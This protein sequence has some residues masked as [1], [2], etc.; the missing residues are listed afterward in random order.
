MEKSNDQIQHDLNEFLSTSYPEI[1]VRVE[2][3]WLDPSRTALFFVEQ[4]FSLIYPQQRFHYLTH[5]IPFEYQEKYLENT[6]WFELAPGEN[7][8]ELEYPDDEL[9]AS[10]MPDVMQCLQKTRFFETLDDHIYPPDAAHP[11]QACYGDY[12][13]SKSILPSK[14]FNEDEYFDIFHVLMAQGGFCDCE[15]LYNVMD[16]KSAQGRVLERAR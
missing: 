1:Q 8:E 11:R 10:I 2:P 9:I 5:L 13:V 4:K 15:I 12:R 3:F 6:V 16:V 7:P 14:G